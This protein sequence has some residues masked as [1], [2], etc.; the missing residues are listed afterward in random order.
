MSSAAFSESP[1]ADAASSDSK[2]AS[3]Y[4][5]GQRR[6]EECLRVLFTVC[7]FPPAA[8]FGGPAVSLDNLTQA[9]SPALRCF[10]VTRDHDKGSRT[11]LPGIHEGWNDRN[12]VSVLYLPNDFLT[13]EAARRLLSENRDSGNG[14]IH[15]DIVYLNSVFAADLVLPMLM[16]AGEANIPVIIAPRGELFDGALSIRKYKKIPYLLLLKK[17]WLKRGGIY[18]HATSREEALQ[19]QRITGIPNDRIFII[20]ETP[21]LPDL[22]KLQ[23]VPR[24]KKKGELDCVFISRIHPIKNL[25]FALRTLSGLRGNIRFSIF[26]PKEDPAYWEEC[27]KAAAALPPNIRVSYG[28]S[29]DHGKIH[30][31]F[32]AHHVFLF[33]T[34]TE[35]YG[36]VILESLSSGCPVLISRG[37]TP[38]DDIGGS[39]AEG[40]SE[41]SKPP[42]SLWRG[43]GCALPLD[44]PEA[45]TGALQEITDMDSGEFEALAERA[46]AYAERHSDLPSILSSYFKMFRQVSRGAGEEDQRDVFPG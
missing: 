22:S 29:L 26:G 32:A 23:K 28:G 34:L 11:R 21:T 46:R 7:G 9:L 42:P 6:T 27:A 19:I 17:R 2:S 15:P 5:A 13:P 35:N 37:T 20:T 40:R 31:T 1:A 45:F 8:G 4:G 44:Q 41:S 33:P 16:A 3:P 39:T 25:I 43:A 24:N 10:V 14:C 30:E 36:H 12:G 38:W 18:W